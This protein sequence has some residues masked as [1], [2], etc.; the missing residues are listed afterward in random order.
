[1][2]FLTKLNGSV[3]FASIDKSLAGVILPFEACPNFPTHNDEFM[4]L[5]V[6]LTWLS[7]NLFFL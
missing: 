2:E 7:G 1:L 6:Q 5:A 4:R 3:Y